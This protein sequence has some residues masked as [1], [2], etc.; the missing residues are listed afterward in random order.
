MNT[1]K[2]LMILVAL[3]GVMIL[4]GK[5]IAGS[6]MATVFNAS[7]MTGTTYCLA[8]TSPTID[9]VGAL[10][11]GFLTYQVK[12]VGAAT[13]DRIMIEETLDGTNWSYPTAVSRVVPGTA[14]LTTA[15]G[16]EINQ[17]STST[18]MARAIRFTVRCEPAAASTF[19]MK[20]W[21][22]KQSGGY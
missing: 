19:T 9:L 5:A 17:L 12:K 13:I 7:S 10:P 4:P 6:L 11:Q 14:W 8:I 15:A 16:N 2:K 3:V 22:T 1:I 18:P 20:L 21:V